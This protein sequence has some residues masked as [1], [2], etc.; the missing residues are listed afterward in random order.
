MKFSMLTHHVI[1]FPPWFCFAIHSHRRRSWCRKKGSHSFV[2]WFYSI[3]PTL[4]LAPFQWPT[5]CRPDKRGRRNSSVNSIYR[6]TPPSSQTTRLLYFW[7]FNWKRFFNFFSSCSTLPPLAFSKVD[8][9]TVFFS[10][11]SNFLPSIFPFSSGKQKNVVRLITTKGDE[12]EG[13]KR[14][15]SWRKKV[16]HG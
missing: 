5:F 13:K 12:K 16:E 14:L 1:F 10:C 7:Q 4:L 3:R 8:T 11:K 15:E 9:F 6:F 2:I